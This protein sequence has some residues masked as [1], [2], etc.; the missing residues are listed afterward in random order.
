MTDDHQRIDR[1]RIE[2]WG[3]GFFRADR[4]GFLRIRPRGPHGPEVRLVD[5]V[6]A[7]RERGHSDP[8]LLRFPQILEERRKRIQR[9]FDDA[10]SEYGY[11][12]P[13]RGVFPVKVNHERC[14]VETLV[15]SGREQR[16]GMEVGSKAE[17]CLALTLDA[18][19]EAFL[20][21]NGFKDR[22]YLELAVHAARHG[23]KVLLIAENPQEIRDILT[24]VKKLDHRVLIGFR[25]RLHTEGTGRWQDSSGQR[26]KFGLSTMEILEGVS[27]LEEAGMIDDL[28]AMHFH[29]GSQ[30]CDILNLKA[31]IKE[32]AR[33]FCV[34]KARAPKLD[35]L[36]LGG[37]LGVDYDGSRTATEWSVNYSLEEYA[38]DA[39]YIVKETCDR[40]RV[41]PPILVTESGRALTAYH[42]VLVVSSL[43][44]VGR[45]ESRDYSKYATTAHQIDDMKVTLEEIDDSNYREAFHDAT[46]L[47][48]EVLSGF[49]LGYVGLEDR[50]VAECL[51][52]DICFAVRKR[53][54]RQSRRTHD[55]EELER[56]LAPK[57]V[58]NFSVFM[59]APD[60]WAVQQL[61]PVCPL[62]SLHA[63]ERIPATIGDITC[64]SDGKVDQFIGRGRSENFLWLPVNGE[65]DLEYDI[66]LFLAG[67]YQ[68]VLGDFHNLFGTVNEAVIEV[69]HSHEFNV[70]QVE[71]G[72]SV[73]ESLDYFGFA[74]SSMVRDFDRMVDRSLGRER[75]AEYK[76]SFLRVLHGNTYLNRL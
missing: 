24:T 60:S 10:I 8:M 54:R 16:F 61:F 30:V 50:A 20:V 22:D 42:A 56:Q 71:E 46:Q 36:D 57:F 66:G 35:I 26:G 73:E 21:C 68:D 38:R 17:L 52:R 47:L 44:V 53:M 74:P 12:R 28:V 69:E 33:L 3:A 40:A 1:D 39:V 45:H 59:S 7:L 49:K 76:G 48:R 2:D 13:Y 43:R 31:A 29:M 70:V 58:C 15:R 14:V 25:T 5:V 32:T 6:K 9:A 41:R 4:E 55:M 62:S 72:S 34:V 18:H 63:A 27:E 67:A 23:R 37:G 75:V 51:Y 19:P 11:P 64:D 65:E